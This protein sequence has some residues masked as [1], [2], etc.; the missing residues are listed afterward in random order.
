MF[1]CIKKLPNYQSVYRFAFL[2]VMRLPVSSQ[3]LHQLTLLHRAFLWALSMGRKVLVCMLGTV[4]EIRGALVRS[5]RLKS[6]SSLRGSQARR[7]AGPP[8]WLL[9]PQS[10]WQAARC[11]R[12]LGAKVGATDQEVAVAHPACWARSRSTGQSFGKEHSSL[13]CFNSVRQTLPHNL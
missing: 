7:A 6:Y 11:S 8:P 1:N 4:W 5:K 12:Q 9:L 3:P 13:E 2:L 10:R